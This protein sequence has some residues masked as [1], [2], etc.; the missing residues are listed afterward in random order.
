MTRGL[1]PSLQ[2]RVIGATYHSCMDPTSFT[3]AP[4]GWQIGSD[5]QRRRP[6]AWLALDD[7][8]VGWPAW[9][10]DHLV[11][12]DP[13]LGISAPDVMAELKS[14]LAAMHTL[15]DETR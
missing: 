8:E 11:R 12:A 9:C 13:K 2:A 14:K 7:D 10:R 4:R 5:V 6:V 3:A 1:T 15:G